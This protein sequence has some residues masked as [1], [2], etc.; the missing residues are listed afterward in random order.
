MLYFSHGVSHFRTEIFT[1][2]VFIVC[3]FTIFCRNV[4]TR[5]SDAVQKQLI[6][7][8]QHQHL[9][10]G[11]LPVM[12]KMPEAQKKKPTKKKQTQLLEWKRKREQ[13]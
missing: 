13:D 11:I 9:A 4:L 6:I 12:G 10:A 1:L 3:D 7:F 2:N 5:G 8:L